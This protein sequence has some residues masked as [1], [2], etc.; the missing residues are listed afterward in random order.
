MSLRADRERQLASKLRMAQAQA[1][2]GEFARN[3][4]ACRE[5]KRKLVVPDTSVDGELK[6]GAERCHR[7]K[8]RV[9]EENHEYLVQKYLDFVAAKGTAVGINPITKTFDH[10]SGEARA[11]IGIIYIEWLLKNKITTVQQR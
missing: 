7:N 11:A 1:S 6:S 10:M 3:L 8:V 2:G 4:Q 5:A 9:T